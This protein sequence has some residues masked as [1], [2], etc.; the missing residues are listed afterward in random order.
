MPTATAVQEQQWAQQNRAQ[1]AN[2]Q[3]APAGTEAQQARLQQ[4]GLNQ[5]EEAEYASPAGRQQLANIIKEFRRRMK[6]LKEDIDA[7]IAGGQSPLASYIQTTFDG[8][9]D[10]AKVGT[11]GLSNIV[12]YPLMIIIALFQVWRFAHTRYSPERASSRIQKLAKRAMQRLIIRALVGWLPLAS[13]LGWWE[14][15]QKKLH[16]ETLEKL[17]KKCDTE[18]SRMKRDQQGARPMP[19]RYQRALLRL[20]IL[21]T[22]EQ[23]FDA[24]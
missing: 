24:L 14:R 8:I 11:A 23:T 17:Q 13:V 19:L 3:R 10:V 22:M 12:T 4:L 1:Q 16:D 2:A 18:E 7:E 9:S 20:R 6:V 21:F 5:Q 15:R